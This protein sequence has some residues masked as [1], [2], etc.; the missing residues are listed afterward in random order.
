MTFEPPFHRALFPALI[1]S[2]RSLGA[3]QCDDAN[4]LRLLVARLVYAARG[5]RS[6]IHHASYRG[7]P[8]RIARSVRPFHGSVSS[9]SRRK[10]IETYDV[11]TVL[12][13]I[14]ADDG[15]RPVET[16]RHSVFL[17]WAALASLSLVEQEHGRTIPLADNHTL[18]ATRAR[19]DFS[20]QP[21]KKNQRSSPTRPFVR[22]SARQAFSLGLFAR[23]L[24]NISW[25]CSFVSF[26]LDGLGASAAAAGA[27]AAG[28]CAWAAGACAWA[29]GAPTATDSAI[30]TTITFRGMNVSP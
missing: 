1:P 24:A 13:D 12:A 26:S 20:I 17:V 23:H 16:L 11:E 27:C 30:A 8:T 19:H 7:S 25:T 14:D 15:N 21:S 18:W 9:G 3:R 28:A 10:L 5:A 4:S 6:T 22:A 2:W 29:N